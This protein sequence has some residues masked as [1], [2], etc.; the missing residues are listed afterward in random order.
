[1]RSD[2]SLNNNSFTTTPKTFFGRPHKSFF[3]RPEDQAVGWRFHYSATP[4]FRPIEPT[5]IMNVVSPV[6]DTALTVRK[7]LNLTRGWWGVL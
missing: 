2:F 3:C 1:M 7:I 6:E 4:F 5:H